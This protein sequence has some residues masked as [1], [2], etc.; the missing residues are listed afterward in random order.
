MHL[1][2]AAQTLDISLK[3]A[4]VRSNGPAQRVVV[5]KRSAKAE[6]KYGRKLKTVCNNAGVIFSRL[7]IHPCTVFRAVF[8]DDDGQIAGGKKERLIT[9]HTRNPRQKHSA[10]VPAKVRKCQAVCNSI[11]I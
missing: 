9:Q 11:R 4:L 1:R 3:V 7:L 10:A 5:L 6:G 2:L 8:G